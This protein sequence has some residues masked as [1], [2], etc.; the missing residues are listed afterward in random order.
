MV[1]RS[2]MLRLKSSCTLHSWDQ[3]GFPSPSRGTASWVMKRFCAVFVDDSDV[4]VWVQRG[5]QTNGPA[6]PQCSQVRQ[7]T[8]RARKAAQ[9]LRRVICRV[10]VIPRH[11]VSSIAAGG[12]LAPHWPVRGKGRFTL[13]QSSAVRACLHSLL[14]LA[15]SPSTGLQTCLHPIKA[16]AAP[17]YLLSFPST[18]AVCSGRDPHLL[19]GKRVSRDSDQLSIRMVW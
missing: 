1:R 2:L 17:I 19:G 13:W 7:A 9:R 3:E 10:F 8:N 16:C 15:Q 4:P 6:A 11:E 18:I 14:G 5:K 12:R